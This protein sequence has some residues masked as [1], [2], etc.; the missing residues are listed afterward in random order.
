M[1]KSN[2]RYYQFS[3]EE[4]VSRIDRKMSILW[5][6]I[7]IP[8]TSGLTLYNG[9]KGVWPPL[10]AWISIAADDA[11]LIA[12]FLARNSP[13]SS[14]HDQ[15]ARF[16]IA[17]DDTTTLAHAAACKL[18]L[19]YHQTTQRRFPWSLF[20]DFS[21]LYSSLGASRDRLWIAIGAKYALRDR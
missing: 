19:Q 11:L 8:K 6:Q 17:V 4:S 12:A 9:T 5:L 10:C 16:S 20:K 3:A 1:G 18:G 2:S 21:A 13:F 14:L 15:R 7:L